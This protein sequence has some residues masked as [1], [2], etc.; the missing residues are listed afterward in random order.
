MSDLKLPYLN[1]VCIAGRL[2]RD[3]E[4]RAA[5]KA[6]V[7]EFAV[8]VERREKKGETWEGVPHYFDMQLWNATPAVIG[9][10]M[11]GRAVL[12]D[13]EMLQD[14]FTDNAGNN[15]S[16]VRVNAHRVQLLEW[17]TKDGVSNEP[18]A[19]DEETPF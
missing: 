4:T 13:G 1:S 15:R 10:L 7:T 9:E 18:A 12:V 19:D 3:S 17:P 14:R 8:A 5:G 2:T 6:T 11:K 16:K